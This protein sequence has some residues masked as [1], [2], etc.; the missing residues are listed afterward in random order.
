MPTLML[1]G[2]D[3]ALMDRIA[4][5]ASKWS[6]GRADA[7]VRLIQAGLDHIDARRRGADAVNARLT[8]EERS[9]KGRRAVAMRADRQPPP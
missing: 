3:R 6:V 8:P 5:Y 2:L 7:A 9:E 4:A 1:R